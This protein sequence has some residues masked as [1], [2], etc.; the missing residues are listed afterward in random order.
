MLSVEWRIGLFVHIAPIIATVENFGCSGH[1]APLS[2]SIPIA[3][4][5]LPRFTCYGAGDEEMAPSSLQQ[6]DGVIPC[7]S[8]MT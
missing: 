5:G 6:T 2:H 7:H 8:R 3:A 1:A 4:V